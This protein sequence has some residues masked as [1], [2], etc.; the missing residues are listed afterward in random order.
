MECTFTLKYQLT[1]DVSDMDALV[2]RLAEAGCD[3]AM[4]RWSESDRQGVWRWSLS[5]KHTLRMT[6]LRA[7]KKTCAEPYLTVD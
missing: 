2:E 5:V 3:D 4:M 6:Q 1:S 7:P